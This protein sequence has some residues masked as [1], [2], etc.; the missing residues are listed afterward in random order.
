MDHYVRNA[1]VSSHPDHRFYVGLLLLPSDRYL[2]LRQKTVK[3][4]YSARV[5]P[6]T[7]TSAQQDH[8]K[9]I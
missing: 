7:G 9:S 3:T 6:E 1:T 4:M 5:F 8:N 2:G